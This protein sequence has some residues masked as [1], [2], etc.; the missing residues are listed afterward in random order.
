MSSFIYI[1]IFNMVQGLT[2]AAQHKP[3]DMFLY[4]Q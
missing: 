4:L 1:E 3:G 2:S